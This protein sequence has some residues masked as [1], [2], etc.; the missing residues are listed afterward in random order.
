MLGMRVGVAATLAALLV[1][2][3]GALA[4]VL[5]AVLP[6]DGRVYRD[7]ASQSTA[8]RFVG[9]VPATAGGQRVTL[10]VR[11]CQTRFFRQIGGTQTRTGGMWETTVGGGYGFPLAPSG[12]TYQARWKGRTTTPFTWRIRIYPQLTKLGPSRYRVS[13]YTGYGTPLQN[14]AGKPVVL[15]R[16]A[17]Q[18][19][20][21]VRTLRLRAVDARTFVAT[22]NVPT[23][24]LTLRVLA[25][26]KTVRP[27]YNGGVSNTTQS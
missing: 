3:S 14:L 4:A 24:G 27:C 20:V 2:V 13:V 11:E 26:T 5:P 10:L 8:I 1:G 22:F 7:E 9:R 12:S 23:P 18:R 16:L 21:N 19:Y 15:Q 25:P 17:E 6:M